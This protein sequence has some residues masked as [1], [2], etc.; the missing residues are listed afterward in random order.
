MGKFMRGVFIFVAYILVFFLFTVIGTVPA[1]LIWNWLA[2]K[3]L[4]I[5]PAVWLNIPF[6]EMW[7]I[8]WFLMVMI[9]LLFGGVTKQ[10][11]SSHD[12]EMKSLKD[13]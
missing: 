8:F 10:T 9:G 7:G 13:D 6:W 11:L 5:L 4:P 2:P 3:Y 12:G 1:W